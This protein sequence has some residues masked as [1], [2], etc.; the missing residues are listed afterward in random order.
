MFLQD[1][2]TGAAAF[3]DA[4][5]HEDIHV[6]LSK[7][8]E[9]VLGHLALTCRGKGFKVKQ[10]RVC[11]AHEYSAYLVFAGTMMK[12]DYTRFDEPKDNIPCQ[13]GELAYTTSAPPRNSSLLFE[14]DQRHARRCAM[15]NQGERPS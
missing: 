14:G 11:I 2:H 9:S 1:R 7:I 3:G 13:S 4:Q 10:T 6:F 12:Q 5:R 8:S 15:S